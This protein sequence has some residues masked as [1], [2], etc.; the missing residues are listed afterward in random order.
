[1]S[2]IAITTQDLAGY[3]MVLAM[4]QEMVNK[5][6]ADVS[7]KTHDL[8]DGWTLT[9][10]DGSFTLDIKFE[11]PQVDFDTTTTNGCRLVMKVKEGNFS[12]ETIVKVDDPVHPGHK[13]SDIQELAIDMTGNT[14]Y[15]TVPVSQIKHDSVDDTIFE[16]QSIFADL[17]SVHNVDLQLAKNQEAAIAGAT[18]A[19]LETVIHDATIQWGKD[20]PDAL[21]FGKV[22][23]PAI[24][25]ASQTQG[26]LK[27]KKSSYSATKSV[28]ASNQYVTGALNFLLWLEDK[29]LPTGDAIGVF[30]DLLLT[31]DSSGK[32]VPATLVLSDTV[33]LRDYLLPTLIDKYKNSD[34]DKPNLTLTPRT[35]DA[36]AKISLAANFRKDTDGGDVTMQQM[37]VEFHKSS[38][39]YCYTYTMRFRRAHWSGDIWAT[40]TGWVTMT[41]TVDTE[42]KIKTSSYPS[43][44]QTTWDDESAGEVLGDI[45]TISLDEIG[46]AARTEEISTEI[47]T[48]GG[49]LESALTD[50]LKTIELPGQRGGYSLMRA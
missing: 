49:S 16:V 2:T 46:H 20:H 12:T 15:I 45:L 42:G 33:I 29:A 7:Q 14:F 9:P 1:M 41:M 6:L 28:D 43:Y 25:P 3:P 18:K 50:G 37:D 13:K 38:A 34:S 36:H 22:N 40:S 8:P 44:P 17:T 35:G 39:S 4:S 47:N 27:P 24:D 11:A 19:A 23:I 5:R 30:N 21:L 31:K 10:D 32:Y 26:K 48:F